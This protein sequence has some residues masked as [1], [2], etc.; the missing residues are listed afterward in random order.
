MLAA[1][2]ILV[3][4]ILPAIRKKKEEAYLATGD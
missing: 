4:M 3:V 2:F 1:L